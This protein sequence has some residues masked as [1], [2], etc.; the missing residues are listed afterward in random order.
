MSVCKSHLGRYYHL[1][2]WKLMFALWGRLF[3]KR[4]AVL[5]DRGDRICT[6]GGCAGYLRFGQT[7]PIHQPVSLVPFYLQ[8]VKI[9]I[10]VASVINWRGLARAGSWFMTE[11]PLVSANLVG[12]WGAPHPPA[13][14]GMDPTWWWGARAYWLQSVM[15]GQLC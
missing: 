6:A 7:H 8:I 10:E 11:G 14:H 5:V 9:C 1:N 13:W 3:L 12:K 4:R 15:R 2:V